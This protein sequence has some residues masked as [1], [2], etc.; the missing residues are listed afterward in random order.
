MLKHEYMGMIF[1]SVLLAEYQMYTFKLNF[2]RNFEYRLVISHRTLHFTWAPLK[3]G[4]SHRMTASFRIWDICFPQNLINTAQAWQRNKNSPTGCRWLGWKW[5]EDHLRSLKLYW[6]T[7]V[8]TIL[9]CS[10]WTVVCFACRSDVIFVTKACS[11][12]SWSIMR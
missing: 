9:L 6:H 10:K 3:T 2:S 7:K 4:C 8:L 12:T 5:Q 1:Y 11:N